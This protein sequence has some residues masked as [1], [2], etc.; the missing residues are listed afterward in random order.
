MQAPYDP[1]PPIS[2]PARPPCPSWTGGSLRRRCAYRRYGTCP[3]RAP[4]AGPVGRSAYHRR[5]GPAARRPQPRRTGAW[6]DR[7]L[8]RAPAASTEMPPADRARGHLAA[9]ATTVDPDN[10]LTSAVNESASS[11]LLSNQPRQVST[12][13]H[14]RPPSRVRIRPTTSLRR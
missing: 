10:S 4:T 5:T 9:Y 11:R 8:A 12:V 1:L 2:P 6:P 14:C 3:W 7:T 13:L